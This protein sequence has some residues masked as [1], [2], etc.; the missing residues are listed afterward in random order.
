[1]N[2]QF[3]DFVTSMHEGLSDEPKQRLLQ[4][5]KH[6]PDLVEKFFAENLEY[7]AI[8]AIVSRRVKGVMTI[9]AREDSIE[10][11][12]HFKRHFAKELAAIQ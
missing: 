1:M 10:L 3:R 6:N 4:T 8:D 2:P 9:Q 7:W 5:L 11:T 12:K